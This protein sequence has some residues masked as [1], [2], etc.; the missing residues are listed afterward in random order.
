MPVWPWPAGLNPL[1]DGEA[2]KQ[3]W[4]AIGFPTVTWGKSPPPHL[5]ISGHLP[6]VEDAEFVPSLRHV[7][8]DQL[9]RGRQKSCVTPGSHPSNAHG[10]PGTVGTFGVP[11]G[12]T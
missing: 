9:P 5:T 6:D 4:G 12:L 3:S 1:L 8:L 7:G 11:T 2:L 10:P